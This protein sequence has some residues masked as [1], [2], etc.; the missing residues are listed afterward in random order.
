MTPQSRLAA[1]RERLSRATPGEW[2]AAGLYPDQSFVAVGPDIVCKC[3]GHN[4]KAHTN[5]IAHAGG[6][7]GDLAWLLGIAEAA[8]KYLA[9]CD[10]PVPDYV[11]R[12]ALRSALSQALSAYD[13]A[14]GKDNG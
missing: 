1:I 12:R 10:N 11:Y 4:H 9:E 7:D 2:I 8:E 13:T 6:T 3:D 5:L 14:K